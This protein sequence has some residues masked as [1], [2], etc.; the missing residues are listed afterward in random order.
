MSLSMAYDIAR[1]PNSAAVW[2]AMTKD[3]AAEIKAVRALRQEETFT[4]ST[5]NAPVVDQPVGR[6]SRAMQMLAQTGMYDRN[7]YAT[8]SDARQAVIVGAA[9]AGLELVD[10]E[11][12][13]LQGTWPG[14]ASY[15]IEARPASV[16]PVF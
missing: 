15:L 9:A 2:A 3:L 1:R 13:M 14:L 10:V 11:R 5:S 16:P 12:R 4:P 7:R 8:D 6:M